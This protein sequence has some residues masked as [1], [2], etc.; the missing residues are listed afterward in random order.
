LTSSRTSTSRGDRLPYWGSGAVADTKVYGGAVKAFDPSIGQF[1]TG[2]GIHG[3]PIAYSVNG[4]QYVVVPS[5]WGGWMKG[6]APELFGGNRG[7]A[8][9]VFALP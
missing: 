1:N 9:V 3:S 8:L 7:N 4:K 5:G 6:F 2:S